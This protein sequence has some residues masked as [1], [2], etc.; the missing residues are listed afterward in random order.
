[1]AQEPQ[2]AQGSVAAPATRANWARNLFVETPPGASFPYGE[3]RLPRNQGVLW[4]FGIL[5]AVSLSLMMLTGVFLAMNYVVGVDPFATIQYLMR[6]VS[7]GWLI[8]LMHMAGA[9]IFFIVAYVNLARGIYYGTY[10]APR[11]RIWQ[12]GLVTLILMQIT[13]YTGYLLPWGQMSYW[14]TLALAWTLGGIPF[15]GHGVVRWILGGDTLG[16]A[17]LTHFY[18]FHILFAFAVVG[19][20]YVHIRAIRENGPSNRDGVEAVAA[21]DVLPFHPY[22][23]VRAGLA[24]LVFLIL[25]SVVV[26]FIPYTFEHAANFLPADPLVVPSNIVPQWYLLP[27]YAITRCAQ[28]SFIALVLVLAAWAVLFALPWLDTSATRSARY[29]PIFRPA[30]WAFIVLVI[31]LGWAG[32]HPTT[33]GWLLLDR[34]FTLLYFVFF[35]IVLPLIGAIETPTPLPVPASPRLGGPASGAWPSVTTLPGTRGLETS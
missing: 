4:H 35:L 24:V 26:F 6:D 5:A 17:T 2:T 9:S 12:L 1:M 31:L 28:N 30:F 11:A 19:A 25:C 10:K 33:T 8:R 3:T 34:L 13:A 16:A 7:Y 18:T 22:Y 14:S 20:V 32:A 15:V 27:F 29:R 23:T 21:E